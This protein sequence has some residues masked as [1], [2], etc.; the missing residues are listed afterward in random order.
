MF[1]PPRERETDVQR[2]PLR[3]FVS[4]TWL[5]LQPERKAVEAALQRL[6]ADTNF[7]GMEYFGSRDENTRRASLEEVDRCHI[8][9][10]IFAARYGSGITEDEY[11]RARAH[12]LPCFIYFKAES[13][14]TLDKVETKAKPAAKLKKL[15]AELKQA[16][17]VAEFNSPDDLSAR[18]TADLHRWIVDSYQPSIQ[19]AEATT[20]TILPLHQ[21]PPPP[22]DFTGRT[23]E[24]EELTAN[25]ERGVNI[26][27]LQGQGGIGK[28]A[29]ALKLAAQLA[30]R[31]P[32]A[33]FYLDLKGAS[34]QQPVPVSEALAHVIRAYHPTAKLPDNE[35]DL[36]ALYRSVL[37]NQ[38]ALLLMD[39][40]KDARQV[41]PLIPPAD[42]V[43]LVTSRQHFTLPGL[44]PKNLDTL[45]SDD[46]RNL[47]FT[48]A[49]RVGDEA[50]EIAQLCGYLPL[51]L[52]LAASAIAERISLGV[53]DYVRRLRDAQ[54]RLKLIEASLSLSY[55]LLNA[56]LQKHWT[57]LSVF[58]DTFDAEA[59]AA[60]WEVE[61]YVAQDLLDELIKYSLID[62]NE[63][64]TRYS[65]H[66]LARLFADSRLS[67]GER[68]AGQERHA[69]H[70][71]NV[72][73]KAGALY[74]EGVDAL[75]RGLALFDL[76]W[77]NIQTGQ[78]WAESQAGDNNAAAQ[79]CSRY[80]NAGAY[81]LQLRQQPREWIGWL[82]IA[83]PSARKLKDQISEQNIL[84]NLGVAYYAVDEYRHAIEFFE[85]ALA[86]ARD[87]KDRHAEGISL[88]NIGTAYRE[89]NEP[90]LAIEYQE[91]ILDIAQDL[92][93]KRMEE[94]ALLNLGI[95]YSD[96]GETRPAMEYYEQALTIAREIGDLRCESLTLRHM[97]LVLN[98]LGDRDQAIAYSEAALRISEQIGDT[99]AI[100]ETRAQLA[101]W[102]EQE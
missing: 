16:H 37:H 94:P 91:Q 33:Q 75:I 56:E 82:E 5:D 22:G 52:R 100:A 14:I 89:L 79:L 87:V 2:S 88:G 66:D 80:P 85:Q 96:L 44:F 90:R 59:A 38:R 69:M 7:A 73:K 18:V 84:C 57:M 3:V 20:S 45:P 86:I 42:C 77:T 27:G 34:E 70:Y 4:S 47:L 98:K 55:D 74:L 53:A 25:I 43:L 102:R 78:S 9:V 8:Y 68:D 83:I 15:K 26:S 48:I 49:P 63:A 35:E 71:F 81:L 92:G 101:K 24:L 76:E 36:C 50:D 41:A 65:M 1:K 72:L 10:G 11:R 29:L 30:P 62:W 93:D 28:T 6:R 46:A 40:A 58:P 97:S 95:S 23:A 54:Q 21:L 39:N 17:T 32:D 61:S 67:D 64:I 19:P 60:V 12:N 51:A 13:T 31:Y 99:T